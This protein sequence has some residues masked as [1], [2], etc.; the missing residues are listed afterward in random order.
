M[1][2]SGRSDWIIA[3]E[4]SSEG[5]GSRPRRKQYSQRVTSLAGRNK[6]TWSVAGNLV[7]D[8]DMSSGE[9]CGKVNQ[10]INLE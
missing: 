5:V 2:P 8:R 4:P 10:L 6:C 1:T 7:T 9:P 3:L